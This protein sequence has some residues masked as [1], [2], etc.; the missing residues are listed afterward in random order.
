MPGEL[1]NREQV[2]AALEKILAYYERR[3]PASPIPLLLKRVRRLVPM[4]FLDLMEDLAP[5]AVKQFK[6]IGGIGKKS[7]E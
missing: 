2:L 7:E 4:D 5:A 3:E 6:E 1:N